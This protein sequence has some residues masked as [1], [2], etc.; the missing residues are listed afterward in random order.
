MRGGRSPHGLRG[1][2]SA[3]HYFEVLKWAAWIEIVYWEA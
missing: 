2:K 1:L 3:I